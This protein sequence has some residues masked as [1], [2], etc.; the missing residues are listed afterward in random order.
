MLSASGYRW[1]NSVVLINATYGNY[2]KLF[3]TRKILV[4][5]EKLIMDSILSLQYV[6]KYWCKVLKK[7]L[8]YNKMLIFKKKWGIFS[9]KF[10]FKFL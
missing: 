2:I 7:L 8:I 1:N 3:E 5:E 9:Q 6:F 4:I 10:V